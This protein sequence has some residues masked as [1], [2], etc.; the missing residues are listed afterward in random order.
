[1]VYQIV[2]AE[3]EYQIVLVDTVS[4]MEYQMEYQIVKVVIVSVETEYQIVLVVV[5]VFEE[6]E[7]Q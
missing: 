3:M 7:C 4:K 6:R 2:L 5:L 1:M